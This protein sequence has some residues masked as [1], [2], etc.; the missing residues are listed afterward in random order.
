MTNAIR[1]R[2]PDAAGTKLIAGPTDKKTGLGHRRLSILDLSDSANQPLTSQDGHRLIIFNGEVYNFGEI[3][4]Q[5]ALRT[6]SDTEVLVEAFG[7]Y[8][9]DFITRTNGMFA[10]AIWDQPTATLHLYRDRMGIKPLYYYWDGKDFAFASEVKAL[11]TLDLPLTVDKGAVAEY[12]HLGYIAEDRTIYTQ[13]R[14]FPAGH[15]AIF[16]GKTLTFTPFWQLEALYE[17]RTLRDF[18]QAKTQLRALL[19]SAVAYRL[20]SD[21]PFGAFLS[22]GTDSSLV[23]AIAHR[24]SSQP[25]K[26]FSIGFAEASHNEAPY[27]RAVAQAL[28][29]DHHEFILSEAQAQAQVEKLLS[30]YDMPYADSSAIP[31]LL[32]SQMARQHVTVALSGDGGDELFMG[33]GMYRWARRLSHPLVRQFRQPMADLLRR[34][35]GNREKRAASLFE[36]PGPARFKS[37]IFSQEQYLFSIGEV[38]EL[39]TPAWQATVPLREE[40][41]GAVSRTLSPAE[42]QSLFDLQHYLKDDLLVKVDIASMQHALEVRVPL[43]DYRVVQFALNLDESL[44]VRG[45]V[46][47]YLLKELLYDYVPRRLFDRPKWG[48][49]VP[50]A[51]WLSGDL[52]YLLQTYLADEVVLEAG[53]VQVAVVREL[54]RRFLGGETYLYNRLW[55]LILLHRFAKEG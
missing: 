51:R 21:V 39:L 52:R 23:S 32:V 44:K 4:L 24:Q 16:D 12:L 8:G 3:P 55:V 15:R 14:K 54:R 35:G 36:Y 1:H 31:T 5:T 11:K 13:I 47:K 19:E 33:Y 34:F 38:A 2:G 27:A 46:Q 25:L 40:P 48:F 10:L 43:L 26:T 6:R 28:G 42:A 53:I 50:M 17:P 49:A 37:H 30:C 18:G 20:I 45:A 22:G 7:Q 9:P 41:R 29:T